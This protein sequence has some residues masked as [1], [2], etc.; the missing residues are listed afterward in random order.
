[1]LPTPSTSHVDFNRIYEAAEDSFLFLDTLSSP[2]EIQF[3][4][5]R[6]L[7]PRDGPV[8]PSVVVPLVL[9]VGTGSGV[10][11]AF[12]TAN[13]R[14]IFGTKKI[15]T[16]GTDINEFACQATRQT[17]RTACA[18]NESHDSRGGDHVGI[19]TGLFLAAMNGDL[20][21]TFRQMVVDVLIFN[22]PYVPSPDVP[23][24]EDGFSLGVDV[25]PSFELD[26]KLLA[27]SYAGGLDGMEVTNRLIAQLP[28]LLNPQRGVA[29]I[30]LCRQNKPDEFMSRVRSWGSEWKVD[31]VGTSGN[32]A[33]WERLVIVRICR[34][35][36]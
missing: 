14:T 11:I 18:E 19:S 15:L 17:V 33:G 22:P 27:L 12:L 20:A 9:E 1:M 2:T 3:L 28:D 16:V 32:T 10:V 35:G 31:I 34:D 13:A 26:S 8:N 30:L 25:V 23:A 7:V 6:F 4:K 21:S 24:S 5:D 29:Y 36:R